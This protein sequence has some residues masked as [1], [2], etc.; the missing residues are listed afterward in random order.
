MTKADAN[1]YAAKLNISYKSTIAWAGASFIPGIGPYI[2]AVG[3]ASTLESQKRAKQILK[4][5]KKG[6]KVHVAIQSG[7]ISV[8]EWYGKAS[9]IKTS[10][11]KS[12]TKKRGGITTKITTKVNK[13]QGKYLLIRRFYMDKRKYFILL[14]PA[15]I[16]F[17][18]LLFLLPEE[19]KVYSLFVPIVFWI[20]Y[21]G[22]KGKTKL[23]QKN[24]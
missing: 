10:M 20:V 22:L 13:K 16:I 18:A 6:K 24:R 14:V 21:Y 7:M 15:I 12:S 19:N 2:S 17:V 11:P 3:V 23:D 1:A 5:T 9:S 8:K 4:L